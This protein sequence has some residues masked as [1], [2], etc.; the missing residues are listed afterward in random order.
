MKKLIGIIAALLVAAPAAAQETG[1]YAGGSLGQAT[2]KDF[3]EGTGALGIACDD[4]DTAWKIFGG[5]QFNPNFALEAGYSQIGEFDLSAA[6][7]VATVDGTALELVGIGIMPVAQR[8]AVYGKLG[9]YRGETDASSNFG[10]SA[11]ETNTDL[12]YGF[13]VRFDAAR[14]VAL[15]AEWQRYTDVGGGDIGDSDV[16]V[17]SVGVLVRF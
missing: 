2:V 4:S 8:L 15:R 5:Y 12:T 1:F 10:F 3:C 14:N 9:I 16:D 6:G 13:G 17:L 7:D 11:S